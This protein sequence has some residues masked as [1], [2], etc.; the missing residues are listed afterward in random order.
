MGAVR[1]GT[2]VVSDLMQTAGLHVGDGDDT[3]ALTCAAGWRQRQAVAI[4]KARAFVLAKAKAD[5][6]RP[7]GDDVALIV[8]DQAISGFEL[9]SAVRHMGRTKPLS[10]DKAHA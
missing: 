2:L 8:P 7:P 9:H 4:R 3:A 10:Q 1:T 6:A 5:G